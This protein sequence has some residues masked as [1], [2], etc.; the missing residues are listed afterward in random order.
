MLLLKGP[1]ITSPT[2]RSCLP[3]F[4][5]SLACGLTCL[6]ALACGGGGGSSDGT[7]TTGTSSVFLTDAA[8]DRFDEILVTITSLEFRGNGKPAEIFSGRE[9]VNLK[10]LENF[11]D[12]FVF[13]DAVPTG[14]YNKIRLAVD[15]IALV[16]GDEV[17]H[18]DPPAGGKIDLLPRSPFEIREGIN[19]VIEIDMDAKKSIHIVET[20]RGEMYRFRPVVFVTIQ[21]THPPAKL[22]RVHGEIIE[23]IDPM[24]FELCSTVFIAARTDSDSDSDDLDE[25]REGG[26]GDRHRCMTVELDDATTLFDA[27]GDPTTTDSVVVGEEVTVVG[28]YHIV[29]DNHD[30]MMDGS[31]VQESTSVLASR[32]HR[33]HHGRPLGSPSNRDSDSDSDGDTDADSDRD[34]DKDTDKDSDKDSDRDTDKDTDRDSDS[35]SDGDDGDRPEKQPIIFLATVI[36]VGPPGTFLSLKGVIDS[37]VDEAD[38]FDFA[39]DPGQGFGGES[40]VTALLQ[41][42][43]RIFSREGV[44]VDESEIVPDTRAKIDG[45]FASD[46]LG[47]FYKTALLLLDLEV[48]GTTL[49]RGATG[50]ID[51]VTR[52]LIVF[53][54]GVPQCVDVPP[55][56]RIFLVAEGD[57]SATSTE[58][59]F[60]DLELNQ[61]VDV[62]G[63]FE[64]VGGCFVAETII[65]FP[66]ACQ[67]ETDCPVDVIEAL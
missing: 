18:V 6:I 33:G 36:E 4:F 10:D 61:R 60:G 64:A 35:D 21:D 13:S 9:T 66:D 34:S 45:V 20:R 51:E 3:R 30:N 2:P 7:T 47:T 49:L 50:S 53:V 55:D 27:N 46:S 40:L 59:D 14:R 39:L 17:I 29:D 42:G 22:A 16:E 12:L 44:E 8:S 65:A 23:I 67:A 26:I 37:E 56:T 41:D 57:P 24:T 54:L 25:P 1:E 62:F 15:D 58:G 19:L 52:Q 63:Q 43:T 5:K 31:P 38:E 11:S 32:R 48:D 28:A